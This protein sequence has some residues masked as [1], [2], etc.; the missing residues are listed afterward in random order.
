MSLRIGSTGEAVRAVQSMLASLGYRSVREVREAVAGQR[1][2]VPVVRSESIEIDGI[3]GPQTE[4]VVMD[5]QRDEGL[6]SDGIVGPR[7][8]AALEAAFTRRQLE[9]TS[10]GI[11]VTSQLLPPEQ[12]GPGAPPAA[13]QRLSFVRADADRVKGY[14]EG[15][16]RVWLRSDVADRYNRVRKK[17]RQ[18]GAYLTS[19]GGRR[20][21]DAPVSEGRAALSMHYLGRA[22]DLYIWSGMVDPER[23]P[24]VVVLP[25]AGLKAIE[26]RDAALSNKETAQPKRWFW[27]VWARCS[28]KGKGGIETDFKGRLVVT[29]SDRRGERW[30][31]LKAPARFLNLTE[32]FAS[33][34][35]LPIPAHSRFFDLGGNPINAEW[36]H[37]QNEEGMIPGVTTFG[38]ELLRVY[39]EGTLAASAP[40][41]RRRA[42]W[43]RDF[44]FP[45]S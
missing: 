8:M 38:G 31:G 42:I 16:D 18:A 21:L 32:A 34:G 27:E 9:L 41:Q 28:E 43:H 12:Q 22:L 26:E 23:D 3:F 33:E 7:T 10:P 5:F 15:Y 37:F 14:D 19:S 35:F 25:E 4:L 30:K 20:G 44:G 29:Y 11:D 45:R 13:S 36:W 2:K 39:S 24:Y 1:G 6:F 40:W 17:V